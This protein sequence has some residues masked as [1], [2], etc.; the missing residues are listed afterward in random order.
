MF[1]LPL[2]S[3]LC[4]D[5]V[6]SHPTAYLKC[7]KLRNLVLADGVPLDAQEMLD[8]I[9]HRFR[10]LQMDGADSDAESMQASFGPSLKN[11]E[12]L[13]IIG[14]MS[15]DWELDDLPRS[16]KHIT[17][18]NISPLDDELLHFLKRLAEDRQF[19]PNLKTFPEIWSFLQKDCKED[20]KQA[21][22][23][24]METLKQRGLQW[25]EAH[26][27]WTGSSQRDAG[28]RL[29]PLKS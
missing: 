11:L 12:Y 4:I 28:K 18:H 27:R 10:Y 6:A 20:I 26:Y 9:G 29:F 1:D 17:Y 16:I 25:P 23:G 21:M 2:L 3:T 19:L 8:Q 15:C 5:G 24:A 13:E 7:R 22:E 14:G